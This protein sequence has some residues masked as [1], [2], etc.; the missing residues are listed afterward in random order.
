MVLYFLNVL[1]S[2]W[3]LAMAMTL[4]FPILS[5]LKEFDRGRP[6]RYWVLGGLLL[7]TL[8]ALA[9]AILRRQTGWVVREIYDLA[10]WWPLIAVTPVFLVVYPTP[11]AR[12]AVRSPLTLGLGVALVTLWVAQGLP[13]LFLY[14]GD[15]GAGLDSVFN[16]DYLA[17]VT[18]Y[19]LGL[20]V[21]TILA[22]G[23][24]AQA[25]NTPQR[26]L[27][28]FLLAGLLALWAFSLLKTVQIM[29]VR[30]LLPRSRELTRAV[31]FFLERENYFFYAQMVIWGSLALFQMIRARLTRPFGANPALV[32]R[33]RADLRLQLA[34]GALVFGT[35]TLIF[36]SFT[37][38]KAYHSRGPKIDEPIMAQAVNGLI[39][40]DLADFSDG[41][42]RRYQYLT[43]SGTQVRFLVIRKSDTAYGVGLDACDICGQTGYYQRGDQVICK[44]C[45]VVMNKVTIGFPGG[46]NPVP[47]DFQVREGKIIIETRNLEKE[48]RRFE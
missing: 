12:L 27:R 33:A 5:G 1:G 38:L 36:I 32:R 34:L 42:L 45:D 18:G 37:A 22:L 24:M 3:P 19:G 4:I 17:R 28:W 2:A 40:L 8:A 13:S 31:I 29:T 20:L 7:G 6:G 30:G 15:F 44:L 16:V 14:P 21:L 35:L 23:L 11:Q 9:L 46:C 47:L 48:R 26:I 25:R 39:S 10:V 41:R 43:Q